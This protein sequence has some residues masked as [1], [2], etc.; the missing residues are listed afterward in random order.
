MDARRKSRYTLRVNVERCHEKIHFEKQGKLLA[1]ARA[2]PFPPWLTDHTR[3]NIKEFSRASRL[4]LLKF[5]ATV[6]WGKI[7]TS[8]FITLSYPDGTKWD[9]KDIRRKQKYL[10]HRYAEKHLGRQ[11]SGLWRLEWKA[12]RSGPSRGMFVPHFHLLL[13]GVGWLHWKR[14]RAWWRKIL[15]HVG[16]LATDV[17]GCKSAKKASIYVSKYVAKLP[18]DASLDNGAYCNNQGRHWGYF[19][20]EQIPRE[21][22]TVI[23]GLNGDEYEWLTARANEFIK[24]RLPGDTNGFVVLG[25]MADYLFSEFEQFRLDNRITS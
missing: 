18:D 16:P 3:G 5:I 24:W 1:V 25:D 19:R 22:K 21:T 7:P 15:G 10:F 4:R 12:R 13:F 17:Q 6:A 8:L 23:E 2:M 20:P 14:V 9:D 11:I